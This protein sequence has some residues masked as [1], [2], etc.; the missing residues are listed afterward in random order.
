M[1]LLLDCPLTSI[2]P[3]RTAGQF[4][5]VSQIHCHT[6]ASNVAAGGEV[7]AVAGK[8]EIG[9]APDGSPSLLSRIAPTDSEPFG[10]GSGVRSELSFPDRANG[11]IWYVWDT[12]FQTGFPGTDQITWMQ[13][14]DTPDGGESPVK[15]PNFEFFTQGG[16]VFA[17]VP[18]N[19][20]SEATANG[21]P[22]QQQR[23]P[24]ITGR[25]VTAAL[26]TNWATD[27]NGFLE[28][29]YDGQLVAREWSRACGYTDAVGPYLKLGLYDFTHGGITATYSAW[30]RNL[31]V[32]STGHS[33]Q[34]VLGVQPRPTDGSQVLP[35]DPILCRYA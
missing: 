2:I 28:C 31:K 23:V 17:A 21:R 9:R 1:A 12:F 3:G 18:F 35:P 20:P 34:S 19:C 7:V 6:R 30:Y 14:H 32:Y 8:C 4:D 15:Y 10:V 25:W 27:G 29:F 16:W 24:L 22:P 5:G 11:E 26:H 13:V 33:A